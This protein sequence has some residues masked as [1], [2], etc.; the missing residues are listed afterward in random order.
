MAT[1]PRPY[2]RYPQPLTD[3]SQGFIRR[4]AIEVLAFTYKVPI[5]ELLDALSDPYLHASDYITMSQHQ[6]KSRFDTEE[7]PS[8]LSA[9]E[10]ARLLHLATIIVQSVNHVIHNQYTLLKASDMV[11]VYENVVRPSRA[12]GF[13]TGYTLYLCSQYARHQCRPAKYRYSM[14]HFSL[15]PLLRAWSYTDQLNLYQYLV[16][17]DYFA[18]LALGPW[19]AARQYLKLV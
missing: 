17:D 7:M 3:E 12:L 13:P 10:Q 4:G 9:S 5:A 1:V 16:S 11:D 6:T 18:N 8:L 2:S 19:E 14:R 15:C